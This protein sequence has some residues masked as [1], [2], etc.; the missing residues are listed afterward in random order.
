MK[1][2]FVNA[3]AAAIALGSLS[4]CSFFN[5]AGEPR[6][7]SK[8][9]AHALGG[10]GFRSFSV[11]VPWSSFL[12]GKARATGLPAEVDLAVRAA[13]ATLPVDKHG[14]PTY[15][16]ESIRHRLVRTTAYSC[17]ENEPGAVG[18]LSA[19]GTVLKYGRVRSA[20]ADWSRYPVGTTFRIKGLPYVYVV[21]DYGSALVGTNTI[22]IYHPNLS[23]MR[24]WATRDAE[25]NIIKWG[26]WERT[27]NLLRG[28]TKYAHCAQMYYATIAKIRSGRV[29]LRKEP[30][31]ERSAL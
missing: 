16:S 31:K 15:H 12:A 13:A 6:L 21:E 25:I 22:D 2:L 28:R 14:K 4:S 5:R 27:A 30:A 17:A 11:K 10:A 7:L 9:E 8:S 3:V 20:A 29:V 1:A 18:S 19:L 23:L 26:S 24:S